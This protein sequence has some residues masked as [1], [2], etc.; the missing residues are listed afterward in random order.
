MLSGQGKDI[1]L[2][3][4]IR[5][6]NMKRRYKLMVF[7]SLSA[8]LAHQPSCAEPWLAVKKGLKCMVCHTNPTGGGK[9]NVYGNIFAQSELAARRIEIPELET[10]SGDAVTGLGRGFWTGELNRFLA[11]GGDLRSN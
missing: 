2:Y 6:M 1:S 10:A 7:I 5:R 4:V 3:P 11:I 9:R 8:I